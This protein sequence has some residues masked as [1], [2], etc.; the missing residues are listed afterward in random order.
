MIRR[1]FKMSLSCVK[2]QR[3]KVIIAAISVLRLRLDLLIAAKGTENDDEDL[4]GKVE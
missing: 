1:P 4:E 2:A 3:R